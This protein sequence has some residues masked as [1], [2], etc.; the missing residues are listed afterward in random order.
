M[1][2][3]L[4]LHSCCAPCLTSV[5]EQL[6]PTYDIVVFWYNPNI[7]PRE[8][9]D[10]RLGVLQNYCHKIGAELVLANY[11]YELEHKTWL[12]LIEGAENE[13]EGGPR[14]TKCFELRLLYTAKAAVAGDFDFFASE[15]TVSPHKNAKII[16]KLGLVIQDRLPKLTTRLSHK[17]PQYLVSDFKKNDGFKRSVEICKE[18]NIYRQSYC[19]CEYS[20]QRK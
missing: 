10:K 3:K 8:E 19:G 4:L 15:L 14:C 7:W 18:H 6:I 13:A 5:Y 2:K 20:A 16:N 1:K 11:E 17:Y 9:H 12:K